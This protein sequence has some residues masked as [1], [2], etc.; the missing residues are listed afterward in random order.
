MKIALSILLLFCT[1][2]HPFAQEIP[3][4]GG[5]EVLSGEVTNCLTSEERTQINR[6]LDENIARLSKEGIIADKPQPENNT[7]AFAWPLRKAPALSFNSYYATNNYVDQNAGTGVLDYNCGS[8]TYDGHKGTDIDTW[9]FPWYLYDNN[10]VEV[11]AGMDGTIIA[12]TDGNVDTHCSCLGNWNAVYVLHADGSKAWYGHMKKNS[13]TSKNIGES[14]AKGEYL[15]VVASSG[16]STQPHLHFEVYDASAQ[17]I[18]PY[19]GSCNS[20]NSESWWATQPDNREPTLNAVI[21]HDALPV[22]GCP[23]SNEAPNISN[24]FFPG[25][26][27]YLA[28]YYR[29]ESIGTLTSFKL[30]KPDNSVW[31]S[32]NHTANNTYTKSWWYWTWVLPVNGPFGNW[33]VEAEYQ[34]VK[35]Q[36]PFYYQAASSVDEQ[37]RDAAVSIYPNPASNFVHIDGPKRNSIKLYDTVGKLIIS[38]TDVQIIDVSGLPKG[39]YFLMIETGARVFVEKVLKE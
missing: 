31:Q 19:S 22:H 16:C 6:M 38:D 17:L 24:L 37:L 28:A 8:R 7:V 20:L 27:I 1:I 13:L 12:K 4:A 23:G 10:L 25:Q 34:G 21:T 33:Q 15:G 9:P 14:V 29:D 18:D 11:V 26:T 35:I 30:L 2:N 39:L 5:G 32:W 36:H 3:P